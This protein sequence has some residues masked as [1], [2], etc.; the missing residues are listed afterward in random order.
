TAGGVTRKEAIATNKEYRKNL[1]AVGADPDAQKEYPK[2]GGPNN[3]L[4]VNQYSGEG[5]SG[6][7]G[8]GGSGKKGGAKKKAAAKKATGSKAPARK[9]AAKSVAAK[10]GS[11]K[12]GKMTTAQ[13]LALGRKQEAERRRQAEIKAKAKKAAEK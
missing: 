2:G 5:G 13:I 1:K 9:A 10:S 3:P 12:L 7:G 4:G 8:K 6:G 11:S